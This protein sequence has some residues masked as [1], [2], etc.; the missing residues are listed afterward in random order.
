MNTCLYVQK[1]HMRTPIY[2]NVHGLRFRVLCALHVPSRV[3]AGEDRPPN[4]TLG[5]LPANRSKAQVLR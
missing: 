2:T 1:I 3:H 4:P 5:L